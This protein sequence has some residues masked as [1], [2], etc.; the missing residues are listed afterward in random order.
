MSAIS[1]LVR[2]SADRMRPEVPRLYADDVVRDLAHE[3]R[4][5]LSAIEAI[6][7]YLEMTLPAE[8][9]AVRQHL[10]RIQKLVEQSSDIVSR[11]VHDARP[12]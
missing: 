4:Q 6:A 2:V 12:A 9:V 1:E 3:L 11:A 8:Q 5:P 7:Y 10:L